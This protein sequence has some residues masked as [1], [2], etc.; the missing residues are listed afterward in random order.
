[1]ARGRRYAGAYSLLM[2]P[3]LWLLNRVAAALV[4]AF[5]VGCAAAVLFAAS[6]AITCHPECTKIVGDVHGSH[7][8]RYES[9]C[10]G[11]WGQVLV[12]LTWSCIGSVILG[13]LPGVAAL[14]LTPARK[15]PWR[16]LPVLVAAT[17]A[18][19]GVWLIVANAFHMVYGITEIIVLFLIPS[20]TG[21]FAAVNIEHLSIRRSAIV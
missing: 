17:V 6:A 8:V 16:S 9:S 10:A 5:L 14:T 19:V 4:G 1:M 20:A 18:G 3:V 7:C 21:L 2:K 13:T 15:K 12:T 11:F